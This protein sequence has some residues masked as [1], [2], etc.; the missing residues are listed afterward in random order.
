MEIC[1]ERNKV[2]EALRSKDNEKVGQCKKIFDCVVSA[3]GLNR[4]K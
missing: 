1:Q 3:A 2:G 4:G